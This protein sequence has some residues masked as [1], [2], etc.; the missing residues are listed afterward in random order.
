MPVHN[1]HL[2]LIDFAKGHCDELIVSMS[3]TLEDPIDGVVRLEWLKRIFKNSKDIKVEM[4]ADDFDDESKPLEQRTKLWAQF[5]K[6]RYPPVD[7][8]ISSEDY[9]EP[10]ARNLGA[11]HLLFDALRKRVPVSATNIRTRP[12]QYWDFIPNVVKPYFVRK[13]CFFG[14]ESTGK[15]TMAKKM[16]DHY[17]TAFVP[18]V[19]REMITS[20]DFTLDDIIKIGKAQTERI[21]EAGKTANRILFCDTDLI[22]TQIYSQQ[23]LKEIP[24]ILMELEQRIKFDL[25][26]LF[27]IDVPWVKD[28]LRDLG[29]RREAMMNI[30]KSELERRGLP[31]VLIR[32][33]W[34]ER[35]KLIKKSVNE[36]TDHA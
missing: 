13:V 3:Y 19:A 10:F 8:V 29:D 30:F 28:G 15:S 32:G 9:G 35:F 26:F 12:M 14:P 33:T 31:F 36:L 4:V 11:R 22:T 18:E 16:A 21:I 24:S 23:Y 20:N 5:I 17:N 27:D 7:I 6:K 2:S 1:G 25:Y 34:E